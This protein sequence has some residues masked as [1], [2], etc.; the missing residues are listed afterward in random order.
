M[1]RVRVTV[2]VRVVYQ[3]PYCRALGL[4]FGSITL[5]L[6]FR[7]SARATKSVLHTR[8]RVG[9]RIDDY[10]LQIKVLSVL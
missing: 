2:S 3:I 5:T 9:V 4:A 1:V 7:P 6:A 10:Q 8:V